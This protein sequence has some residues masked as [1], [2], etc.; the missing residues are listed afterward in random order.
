VNTNNTQVAAMT[1]ST[2]RVYPFLIWRDVRVQHIAYKEGV[3]RKLFQLPGM[4]HF[5]CQ[6]TDISVES[7]TNCVK[8]YSRCAR[9]FANPTVAFWMVSWG[10]KGVN[11]A[12]GGLYPACKVLNSAVGG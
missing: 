6:P 4:I 1:A 12:W 11:D 8:M 9:L 10:P 5:R 3:G 7:T 2:Q